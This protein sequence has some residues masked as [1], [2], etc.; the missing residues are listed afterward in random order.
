MK[1]TNKTQEIIPTQCYMD[2]IFNR[3]KKIQKPIN[4]EDLKDEIQEIRKEIEQLK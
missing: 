3:F 4:I 2:E 1:N